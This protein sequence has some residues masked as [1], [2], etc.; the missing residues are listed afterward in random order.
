MEALERTDVDF[1]LDREFSTKLDEL[2]NRY[3][4]T[5]QEVLDIVQLVQAHEAQGSKGIN[6]LMSRISPNDASD[7]GAET[8]EQRSEAL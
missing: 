8:L 6:I 3:G 4:Y 2:V 7:S 5:D 1:R